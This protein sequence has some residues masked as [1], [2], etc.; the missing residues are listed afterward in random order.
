[1]AVLGA[2][3]RQKIWRAFMRL[4][5]EVTPFLKTDLQAAVDATDAWIDGQQATFNAALPAAFRNNASLTQKTL[6]FCYVAMRRA[7]L[8]GSEGS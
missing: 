1:M 2:P 3:E 5:A 8:L 4:N 6:L 7:G